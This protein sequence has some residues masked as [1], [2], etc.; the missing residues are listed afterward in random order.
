MAAA[1]AGA[2]LLAAAC[3]PQPAGTSAPAAPNAAPTAGQATKMVVSYSNLIADNLPEWLAKESGIF[4]RHNLDVDLQNVASTTG[5][6]AILA[7]EIQIGQ[8]GGSEVLSAAAG[9]ADLVVVANLAAVYP[10]VFVVAP[11]IKTV[12]DLRG[13]KIG[14]SNIGS[15]SDIATRVLLKKIGLDAEKDVSIVAVGSLQNRMAALFSGAIQGGVAQPPDQLALEDKGFHVLFD[16]ADLKLPAAN[17]SVAAKRTWVAENKDVVQGYVDSLV[18]AIALAKKDRNAAL[19]VLKKYLKSD[20]DRA[21]NATY[22]FFVKEVS[23]S[24]PFSKPEQFADAQAQ[25]GATND[26]V[27][28]FDLSKLFDSSFV[29]SAVNRGLAAGS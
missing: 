25:L 28:S 29:Q 10:F 19:P 21:I 18:E 7:G 4:Q 15:S 8:L 27:K 5:V 24:Q 20:D 11:E 26:K 16:L 3:S 23:P 12:D 6:P 22:D 14:V 1:F 2:L 17:T 13:K 9:G